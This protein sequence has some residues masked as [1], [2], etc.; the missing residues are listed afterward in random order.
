M[1]LFEEI[2]GKVKATAE[3]T[4]RKAR[5]IATLAVVGCAATMLNSCQA[6]SASTGT[7]YRAADGTIYRTNVRYSVSEE[8]RAIERYS[9]EGRNWVNLINKLSR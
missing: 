9:R 5:P 4:K 8:S 6:T 7:Y 3:F 2:K 1:N